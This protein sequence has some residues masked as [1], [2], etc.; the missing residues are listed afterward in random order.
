MVKDYQIILI[1][2][3]AKA[4]NF[5]IEIFTMF[6]YLVGRISR[7]YM[8]IY[9]YILIKTEIGSYYTQSAQHA[10]SKEHNTYIVTS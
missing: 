4:I 10:Q 5:R 7:E 8:Y 6:T 3:Y 9:I 1:G 2:H